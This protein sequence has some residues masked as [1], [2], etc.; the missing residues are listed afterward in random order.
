M[1]YP[2]GG[3]QG[4]GGTF[5]RTLLMVDA[6]LQKRAKLSASLSPPELAK[7]RPDL[8][9]VIRDA[10]SSNQDENAVVPPG[11]AVEKREAYYSANF[12]SVL[13]TVL[14]D[15]PERHVISDTGT[16]VVEHFL[17]LSGELLEV[18]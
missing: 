10:E 14:S 5:I 6:P 2:R 3:N 16:K 12:K 4:F 1:S 13:T 8:E 17:A 18:W 9:S 7:E 15:S 11:G